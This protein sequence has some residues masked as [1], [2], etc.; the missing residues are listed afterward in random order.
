MLVN[1]HFI[2]CGH[3]VAFHKMDSAVFYLA[4]FL[5]RDK[6][7]FLCSRWCSLW[8]K[9]WLSLLSL[10]ISAFSQLQLPPTRGWFTVSSCS[11]GELNGGYCVSLSLSVSLSV[12][13][14]VSV[15]LSLF[16]VLGIEFRCSHMLG[17]CSIAELHHQPRYLA[18]IV[19][20]VRSF[21]GTPSSDMEAQQQLDMLSSP[22]WSDH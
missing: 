6:K 10:L 2:L 11:Q 13:V 21:S 19:S 9:C 18:F 8:F 17:K 1:S 3:C 20:T 16:S 14:S 12:S 5:L 22:S 4:T 7:V 15:S